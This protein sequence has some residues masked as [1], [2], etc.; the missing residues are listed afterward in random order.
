MISETNTAALQALL[1][2]TVKATLQEAM[3]TAWQAV[4]H[5]KPAQ[6]AAHRALGLTRRGGRGDT[7]T[8]TGAFSA[9]SE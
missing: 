7:Q 2:E 9:V 6:L 4:V 3:D 5:Q 8:S 1:Q